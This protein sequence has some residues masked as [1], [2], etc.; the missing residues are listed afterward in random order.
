[1]PGAGA[2]PPPM[3]VDVPDNRGSRVVRTMRR[4]TSTSAVSGRSVA[5]IVPMSDGPMR[6]GTSYRVSARLSVTSTSAR[7]GPDLLGRQIQQRG[8]VHSGVVADGEF[9]DA[10]E[11]QASEE[12]QFHAARPVD[13]TCRGR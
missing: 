4:N 7:S 3:N 13:E 8:E 11:Q 1:M 10:P 12:R 9:T 6:E 5:V 2:T